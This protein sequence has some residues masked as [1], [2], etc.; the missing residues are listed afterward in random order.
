MK[1]WHS[2]EQCLPKDFRFRV[3]GDIVVFVGHVYS[4]F[5]ALL[6]AGGVITPQLPGQVLTGRSKEIIL[7]RYPENKGKMYLA[8][9][10]KV[11]FWL[12]SLKV[13]VSFS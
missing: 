7:K 8:S 13:V 11:V 5:P 2:T 10:L 9:L 6:L 12:L 3:N 1:Q 4:R